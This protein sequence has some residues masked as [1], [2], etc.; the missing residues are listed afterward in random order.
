MAPILTANTL[1]AR[2]HRP[3]DTSEQTRVNGG[4]GKI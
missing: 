2:F 4:P 3:P 1:K